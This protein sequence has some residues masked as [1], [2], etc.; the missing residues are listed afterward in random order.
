MHPIE[1]ARELSDLITSLDALV[2]ELQA[3]RRRQSDYAQALLGQIQNDVLFAGSKKLNS[4]GV[5]VLE[6]PAR[7]AMIVVDDAHGCGPLV[8]TAGGAGDAGDVAPGAGRFLV[9]R[10]GRRAMPM[11]A[12]SISIASLAPASSLVTVLAGPAYATAS[13]AAAGSV[14]VT[15]APATGQL[16]VRS[17][18]LAAT[19][20]ATAELASS[21]GPVVL[22]LPGVAAALAADY[23]A[24][25]PVLAPGASLVL[26]LSAAAAA[27]GGA[28]TDVVAPYGTVDI[29][30][31][32]RV[33]AL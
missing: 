6:F 22:E 11:V 4:A 5:A 19:A 31:L 7:S 17:A 16:R 28:V 1:K 3:E 10:G 12:Q 25:G 18:W 30:V 23:G 14:Q 9:P 33:T 32:T 24:D 15:A 21:A 2:D 29:A 20:A 27:A 13:A 8:V 26:S